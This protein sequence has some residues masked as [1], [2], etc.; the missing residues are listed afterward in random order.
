MIDIERL[1]H[2]SYKWWFGFFLLIFYEELMEW[3]WGVRER[4][5]CALRGLVIYHVSYFY[6]ILYFFLRL[7]V[8]L[9]LLHR[10]DLCCHW[11]YE[12]FEPIW[13]EVWLFRS[14]F[15][16]R[17]SSP[18]CAVVNS[19]NINWFVKTQTESPV[20]IQFTYYG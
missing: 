6:F 8:R 20:S 12:F 1:Q 5:M 2:W 10:T 3:M 13:I 19:G 15:S 14:N 18:L 9:L 16:F 17:S 4:V 7:T 11:E